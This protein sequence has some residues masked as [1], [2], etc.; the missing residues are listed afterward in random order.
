LGG[1]HHAEPDHAS[2]LCAVNDI[3]VAIGALRS[4]GFA[5]PIAILDL[6]AHPPD[7]TAVCLRDD[8]AVWIGSISGA[9]W[10]PLERVDETVLPSGTGDAAYLEALRALLDR[11]PRPELAFVI[12]GGD[13][14]ASDRLGNLA[15]S[16]D[17]TRRRDRMVARA[18]EG[19]GTVWL[20]GGGYHPDTWKVLAGTALAIAGSHATVA[21]GYDAMRAGYARIGPT[22]DPATLGNSGDLAMDD[23]LIDLGVRR[24]RAERLLGF[25]TVSGIEH[26]LERYGILPH[27]RR[28]G[29]HRFE[30]ELDSEGA[31]D[32]ARLYA[33]HD[34]TRLLLI[35]CVLEKRRIAGKPVLYVHWLMMQDAARAL[36][37]GHTPLPGQEHPG[38]GLSIE[39]GE[40]F[41]RMAE[42]LGLAGVAFTPSWYH[43]AYA[44][45]HRCH[46]VD[47]ARQGRFEALVRDL[48]ETPLG[49]S[50]RAVAEGRVNRNGM[51]YPWE[52]D[53]MVSW[54]DGSTPAE[55]AVRAERERVRFQLRARA[56]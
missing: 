23:L 35:E 47:A 9:D 2:S 16:L 14:L 46:F 21:E 44:A 25:Y 54:L 37:P 55:D 34:S 27:L 18:L 38:L 36:D 42:R 51:P 32:R 24:R 17:G 29:Y 49:A 7:G 41:S 48:G 39:M 13:V 4:D 11:M 45:R 10:G 6:D 15:M 33:F 22:L 40:L 20:P 28:L 26:A 50:T 3:A 19:I 31:R 53:D 43:M 8:P 30:A 1:F 12:A 5:G 56:A 52:A